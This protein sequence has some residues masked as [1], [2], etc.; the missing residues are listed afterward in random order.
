[1]HIRVRA[2]SLNYRDLMIINGLY[3]EVRPPFVPLADGAG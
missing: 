1:V 2:A 3:G